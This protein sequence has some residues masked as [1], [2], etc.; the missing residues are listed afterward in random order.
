[1][2]ERQA[3][4]RAM[5]QVIEV[6]HTPGP[7]MTYHEAD[8]PIPVA[9]G[10]VA[11]SGTHAGTICEICGQTDADGVFSP[12][13]TAANARLIAAAPDMLTLAR[14]WLALDGGAWLVDRHTNEKRQ[15]IEDTRAAIAKAT[16]REP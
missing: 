8:I 13:V 9:V 6:V 10:T 11:G 14:R 12:A 2:S 5:N 7:W 4:G 15:L 3:E 16:G 1:M